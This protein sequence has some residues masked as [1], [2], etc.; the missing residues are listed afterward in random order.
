VRD[1][2]RRRSRSLVA[3]LDLPE[4]FDM[5]EFCTTVGRRR[6]RPLYRVPAELPAGSPS[7]M[8]VATP[9]LDYVF[10]ERRT[11]KLHQRHIVLHELG[12]ILGEHE[13]PPAMSDATS[14]TLLPN[15]DPAMVRRMLARTYFSA[16]EEQ[17]A[18]LVASLIH[19]RISAWAPSPPE[20][21]APVAPEV[22]E[23][24]ARLE[25]VFRG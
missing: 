13:A 18:E 19:E 17:E 6:G 12:H 25:R 15:L 22:A 24:L 9:D 23:V 1:D 7:G 14:R 21:P 2:V 11:T 16:I 4:P 20:P 8:W 3:A 10:Y 5:D